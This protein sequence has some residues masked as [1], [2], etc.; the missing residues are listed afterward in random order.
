[1]MLFPLH[2]AINWSKH[3]HTFRHPINFLQTP[4]F[5]N[6]LRS[7]ALTLPRR[8]CLTSSCLALP[9][10]TLPLAKMINLGHRGIA[11][12][13]CLMLKSHEHRRQ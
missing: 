11:M 3:T 4:E 1:M 7:P 13:L 6:V 10:A 8:K 9:C 2:M 12:T 5:T